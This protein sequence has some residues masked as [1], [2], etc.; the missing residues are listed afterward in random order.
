MVLVHEQ[1]GKLLPL[2]SK[3][4]DQRVKKWLIFLL[5]TKGDNV[6]SASELVLSGYGAS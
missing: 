4:E 2:Y 6:S 3:I 1:S 5:C